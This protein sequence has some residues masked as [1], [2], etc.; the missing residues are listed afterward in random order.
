M[1]LWKIPLFA[2]GI[3][4][5]TSWLAFPILANLS[6]VYFS[7]V[8]LVGSGLF[9]FT[10][11]FCFTLHFPSWP[12]FLLTVV[13]FAYCNVD[14]F[15]IDQCHFLLAFLK[16]L[17]RYWGRVGWP[18]GL[19]KKL[20]HENSL[21][22]LLFMSSLIHCLFYSP[23]TPFQILKLGFSVSNNVVHSLDVTFRPGTS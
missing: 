19:F 13:C 14:R 11:A 10:F 8:A 6:I 15:I 23:S 5:C 9:C 1:S 12:F 22:I 3:Y 20:L 17:S 7:C 16:N 18:Q 21:R 4:T 2:Y